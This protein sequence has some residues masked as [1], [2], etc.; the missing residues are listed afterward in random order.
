[1]E[2]LYLVLVIN[3]IVWSGIFSYQFY[4]GQEIKKLKEQ[5][6]LTPNRG[7]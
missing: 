5:T 4:L 7:V 2:P 3:L 1:M 6:K